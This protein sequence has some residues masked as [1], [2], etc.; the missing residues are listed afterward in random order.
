MKLSDVMSAAN[1]AIYA[2]VGL[3][4]FLL[5]FFG[6][7]VRV[8]WPRAG[9]YEEERMI[10]LRDEPTSPRTLTSQSEAGK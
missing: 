9:A 10:P 7:I 2:E 5:V 8:L 1:L 4:L 3:V 6:V